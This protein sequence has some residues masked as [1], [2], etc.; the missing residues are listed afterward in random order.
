MV[1]KETGEIVGPRPITDT[2]GRIG[3]GMFLD[4][5]SASAWPSWWRQ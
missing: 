3:G 1:D 5:V 4:T 2:L